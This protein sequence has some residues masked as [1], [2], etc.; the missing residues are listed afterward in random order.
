MNKQAQLHLFSP[1]Y[2]SACKDAA[3]QGQY[4]SSWHMQ[5]AACVL[6]CPLVSLYPA[7]NG[8]LD[9]TLR[10]LNTTFMQRQ[11]HA[12][13]PLYIMWSRLGPK[14]AVTWTPNHFVPLHEHP[15]G[16][17]PSYASVAASPPTRTFTATN[18]FRSSQSGSTAQATPSPQTSIPASP[19]NDRAGKK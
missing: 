3:I 4:A 12:K 5:A 15:V 13:E 8:L 18:Y 16:Q 7:K 19:E 11:I 2:S 9:K 1:S 14:E 6:R 10:L 17:K